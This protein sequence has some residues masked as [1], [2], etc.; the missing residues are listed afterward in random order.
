V[1]VRWSTPVDL[2]VREKFLSS[3]C[4][5]F[6]YVR[7]STDATRTGFPYTAACSPSSIIF[8]GAEAF[9]GIRY[10]MDWKKKKGE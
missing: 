1:N 9:V 7:R 5:T 4:E 6:A 3:L 2:F 8:A 10:M